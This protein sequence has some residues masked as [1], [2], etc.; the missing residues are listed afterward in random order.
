M[1]TVNSAIIVGNLGSDPE[2]KQLGT[3]TTVCTFSVATT[4]AG[5]NGVEETTWHRVTAW[6]KTAENCGKYLKKGSKV[7][8]EGRI[9]NYEYA[10]KTGVKKWTYELVANRVTFL[11]SVAKDIDVNTP[12]NRPVSSFAPAGFDAPDPNIPF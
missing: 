7:C 4:H 9:R 12:V 5:Q 8:V 1:S 3:G 6:Q 2:S 10:D 11:S